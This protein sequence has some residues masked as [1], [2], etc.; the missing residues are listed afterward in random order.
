MVD[1]GDDAG[2]SQKHGDDRERGILG[3][4][5]HRS[6]LEQWRILQAVVDYGGYVQAAEKLHRSHSSLN[7]AVSKLQ[8]QLGVQL[9][10]VKGRK[11]ELT[12]MGEVLLR[13]SRQLTSDAYELE[14]L[15]NLL[16][17]G[18]ES[19]ICLSV[20]Q[21]YP[22]AK[23]LPALKAFYPISRGTRV[24]IE[25]HVLSGSKEM[26]EQQKADIVICGPVPQGTMGQPIGTVR[27]L[28]VAHP[29][30]AL[31]QMPQ[32]ITQQELARE[33]QL[34]IADTGKTKM[35]DTGWLRSEQRWT[36]DD[37]Y[38]AMDIL[39]SGLGFCWI[40]SH[41]VEDKIAQGKL[42]KLQVK[43]RDHHQGIMSLVLPKSEAIGPASA[44]LSR[45][46]LEF[47]AEKMTENE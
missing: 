41:Y 5:P 47:S 16:N 38:L 2:A 20:E 17:L 36:V 13:R 18:W 28:P 19:E 14:Q 15:A 45:L 35:A 25:E 40:P 24:R 34:V 10:T 46:I 39:E 8:Q 23:L 30:H 29:E 42:A 4:R 12:S 27:F 9:L 1:F 37:F 32:P 21:V 26:I 33:L 11:A 6:N 7:H 43:E 31:I 44:E 3:D 22:K